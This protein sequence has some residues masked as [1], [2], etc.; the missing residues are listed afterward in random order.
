M[1]KREKQV[2]LFTWKDSETANMYMLLTCI[3]LKENILFGLFLKKK[4]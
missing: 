3:E 4:K 2:K 1:K